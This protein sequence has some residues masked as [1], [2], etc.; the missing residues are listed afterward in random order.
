[1][2]ISTIMI[3]NRQYVVETNMQGAGLEMYKKVQVRDGAQV[4]D[5]CW[6]N[7]QGGGTFGGQTILTGDNMGDSGH[8]AL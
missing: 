5:S 2:L 6:I 1:M 7:H 8:L 4:N 3:P